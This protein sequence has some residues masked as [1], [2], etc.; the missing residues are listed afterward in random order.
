MLL[1]AETQFHMTSV[2]EVF[3]TL[4][5]YFHVCAAIKASAD[6]TEP[7]SNVLLKTRVLPH[8][9]QHLTPSRLYFLG[10]RHHKVQCS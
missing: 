7:C 4:N 5:I 1:L 9:D 3:S 6:T 8:S 2:Y 10:N